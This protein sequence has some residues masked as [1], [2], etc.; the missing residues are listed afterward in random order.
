MQAGTPF[1]EPVN[2][3]GVPQVTVFSVLL[4]VP[5]NFLAVVELSPGFLVLMPLAVA[6]H[7]RPPWLPLPVRGLFWQ[8][9][10]F[11]N[12]IVGTDRRKFS[13][14]SV[15]SQKEMLPSVDPL[16]ARKMLPV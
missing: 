12:S 7:H 13:T 1:K 2:F 14:L 4:P 10:D 8:S 16:I 6:F 5:S 11:S 15:R 3:D 9:I